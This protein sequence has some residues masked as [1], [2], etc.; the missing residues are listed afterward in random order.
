MSD[1]FVTAMGIIGTRDLTED[2]L[3]DVMAKLHLI[4]GGTD[5]EPTRRQLEAKIGLN[6]GPGEGLTSGENEPWVEDSKASIKW[7]YWD[8][9]F[10]Q[11][12]SQGFTGPVLRAI[13]EDTDNI[14]TECGNPAIKEGWRIQGLVMGD[15]QSGKTANYCGLIS[16]AA[17]SGYKIIVLLTGTIEELRSQ[18]QERMDEGFVGRDSNEILDGQQGPLIG[19]GRFREVIPNV[20]TSVSSDFLTAKEH[21]TTKTAL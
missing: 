8:S 9:Y 2:V 7:S 5:L 19:A 10:K 11:L 1:P 13:D 20:L 6:M 18:S 15:V 4:F 17:D 3:A 14:L 16:K 12:Q 21:D